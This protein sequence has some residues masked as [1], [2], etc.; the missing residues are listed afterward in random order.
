V[1]ASVSFFF[2][3]AAIGVTGLIAGLIALAGPAASGRALELVSR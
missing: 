1:V 3:F 2:G